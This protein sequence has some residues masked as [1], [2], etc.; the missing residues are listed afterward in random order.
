LLEQ[1]SPGTSLAAATGV[2]PLAVLIE[3]LPRLWK[4][5]GPPFISLA[6]EAQDWAA[7][8]HADWEAAGK[9]CARKLIDAAA[10]FL[11][12]LSTNNQSERFSSIR[13][14][15]ARTSWQQSADP[16]W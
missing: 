6:E 7:T 1:C 4:A 5:V 11:D 2:D 3:L 12:Q 10:E 9:R 14:S 8:L 15:M 16:G 13:I